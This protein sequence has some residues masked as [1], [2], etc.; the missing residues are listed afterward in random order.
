MILSSL[1][2]G[3]PTVSIQMQWG[4]VAEAIDYN[5][6]VLGKKNEGTIY[7]TFNLA[8]RIG[9]GIGQSLAIKML[10]W[11]Y[12]DEK[13][14]ELHLPQSDATV[15]GVQITNALLPALFVFGSWLAFKFIW[16]I[17]PEIKDKIAKQKENERILLERTEQN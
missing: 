9:L 5:E 12:Y 10:D 2:M 13:L 7:G 4:L 11:F 6:V 14:A 17:T 1:A 16:K 15:L 8:R 3:I